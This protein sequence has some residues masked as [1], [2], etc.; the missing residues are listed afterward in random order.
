[1]NALRGKRFAFI[2]AMGF[3]QRRA[4]ARLIEAAGGTVRRALMRSTHY[5]VI[6][7]GA[8]REL[9]TGRLEAAI[10][11]AG[12]RAVRV[13]SENTALRLSGALSELIAIERTRGRSGEARAPY[14]RAL[15]ID[16]D[17]AEAWYNLAHLDASLGHRAAARE[18][19]ERALA[20]DPEYADA[21]FNLAELDYRAGE[22]RAAIASWE[23]YL[24]LDPAGEW[25]R[26]A[27]RAL[28][29]CRHQLARA[30]GRGAARPVTAPL[31][32]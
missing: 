17:D 22:L 7:H 29:V 20:V 8:H 19:L 27:R 2:G 4:A 26:R 24:T 12:R 13:A 18:A 11:E 21:V 15:A 32:R 16:Q 6:G 23:R 31:K 28:T 25:A 10:T 3:G 9:R 5:L 30:T 14:Q 1:V